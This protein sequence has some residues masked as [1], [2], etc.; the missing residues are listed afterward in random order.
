MIQ[1]FDND[2]EEDDSLLRGWL[3]SKL[4]KNL[5]NRNVGRRIVNKNVRQLLL[6][7]NRL[8]EKNGGNFQG[9]YAKQFFAANFNPFSSTSRGSSPAVVDGGE[10]KT[11]IEFAHSG[12]NLNRQEN[13]LYTPWGTV[14]CYVANESDLKVEHY[15]CDYLRGGLIRTPTFDR[16]LIV[17]TTQLGCSNIV[18]WNDTF[19]HSTRYRTV[20]RLEYLAGAA[21]VRRGDQITVESV[22]REYFLT[23]KCYATPCS[24]HLGQLKNSPDLL[25]FCFLRD[26][27][28][29]LLA[30]IGLV[31]K[32]RR[33]AALSRSRIQFAEFLRGFSLTKNALAYACSFA[34]VDLY[35]RPN[36]R[37]IMTVDCNHLST[38]VDDGLVRRRATLTLRKEKLVE[39]SLYRDGF[40]SCCRSN[41]TYHTIY[42]STNEERSEN[43]FY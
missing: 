2:L 42:F 19:N 29:R 41:V 26:L 23:A 20:P 22:V 8:H 32:S 18:H 11:F 37:S 43:V 10:L 30:S 1:F 33:H 36:H 5:E 4:N 16:L 12:N 13:F 27:A 28:N 21:V 15:R 9:D 24:C 6:V 35:A 14:W 3:L 31:R 39:T 34:N 38:D 17:S 40:C 25:M 7:A